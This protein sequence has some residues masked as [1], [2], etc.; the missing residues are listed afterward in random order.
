MSLS[1][2]M[3]AT[4]AVQP[5]D[6]I[7]FNDISDD[8]IDLLYTEELENIINKIT[9]NKA[10]ICPKIEDCFNFARMTNLEKIKVVILGQDPY[11][12]KGWAHGLAFSSLVKVPPS[13]KNIYKCLYEQKLIEEIP[14]SGNLEPWAK[15]GVLL[16]NTALSTELDNSGAHLKLWAPYTKELII[17]ISNRKNIYDKFP[18]FILWGNPAKEYKKVI[19]KECLVLEWTHPSNLS[20]V[21]FTP[22]DN[23]TLCNEY[24]IS[25]SMEPIDWDIM[26]FVRLKEQEILYNSLSIADKEE[27]LTTAIV[28]TDGSCNPNNS[29]KASVAGYSCIFKLG[30]FDNTIIMGNLN[31]ETYNATN[32]RAEGTAIYQVMIFLSDRLEYWNRAIIITDSEFWI[33]S[34]TEWIP[35][36]AKNN[37]LSQRKNP[38]L[39]SN[40]WNLYNELTSGLCT[41]MIEFRFIKGHNR[42]NWGDKPKQSYEYFCYKGNELADTYANKARKEIARGDIKIEFI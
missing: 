13:L 30:A 15:Q 8:W 36:W 29:S 25:H 19:N 23:F 27:L 41:K 26:R 37:E 24:L 6:D 11:Q 17:K 16:L 4:N 5:I 38:D 42:S 9:E 39:I 32:I 21:D 35:K 31:N 12:H 3:N 34:I 28:F 10:E 22:C 2:V 7:L 18:V 20:R 14:P 40:I 1:V 33:K